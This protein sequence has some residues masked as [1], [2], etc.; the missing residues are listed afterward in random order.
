MILTRNSSLAKK[1]AFKAASLESFKAFNRLV[2]PLFQKWQTWIDPV[3]QHSVSIFEAVLVRELHCLMHCWFDLL[4]PLMCCVLVFHFDKDNE[5]KAPGGDFDDWFRDLKDFC[6]DKYPQCKRAYNYWDGKNQPATALNWL[7]RFMREEHKGQKQLFGHETTY[8]EVVGPS[9][10]L[11]GD[12]PTF[13]AKN[14]RTLLK[15][16]AWMEA[17]LSRKEFNFPYYN[18]NQHPIF[19]LFRPMLEKQR[20]LKE[21]YLE[22]K[23]KSIVGFYE[24]LVK[25]LSWAVTKKIYVQVEDVTSDQEEVAKKASV[26]KEKPGDTEEEGKEEEEEEGKED[27]KPEAS[28]SKS[29][30]KQRACRKD[31]R[32]LQEEAREVLELITEPSTP[33][34]KQK[35]EEAKEK[36]LGSGTESD[37]LE[38]YGDTESEEEDEDE[39]PPSKKPRRERKKKA[40]ASGPGKGAPGQSR[41]PRYTMANLTKICREDQY[42]YD[43][44]HVVKCHLCPRI[45]VVPK[46]CAYNNTSGAYYYFATK[47]LYNIVDTA[48]YH[49]IQSPYRGTNQFF[50]IRRHMFAHDLTNESMPLFFQVNRIERPDIIDGHH[51]FVLGQDGKPLLDGKGKKRKNP[52]YGAATAK[53]R[54]QE[55]K[56]K[57][58]LLRDKEQE[59]RTGKEQEERTGKRQP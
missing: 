6:N 31:A 41:A 51:R 52:K 15:N 38:E 20:K 50:L 2:K 14:L 4:G 11:F 56:A 44:P 21:A 53:L 36:P 24:D 29:G 39:E 34:G 47:G 12:S 26:S 18:D 55:Q 33:E 42:N 58:K 1:E 35:D 57:E 17:C 23:D 43:Y 59:E 48:G 16:S 19:K 28:S 22:L 7:L 40:K 10:D 49:S 37:G 9:R 27:E 13:M 8:R 45:S 5:I 25:Q 30:R 54:R 32:N 3:S 46:E